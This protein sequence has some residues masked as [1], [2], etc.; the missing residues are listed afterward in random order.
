M[1]RPRTP[2]PVDP[3]SPRLAGGLDRG[4]FDVGNRAFQLIGVLGAGGD[5][6]GGAEDAVAGGEV[7]FLLE[8]VV[9][10]RGL[11]GVLDL[12]NPLTL[13]VVGDVL[14]LLLTDVA[15]GLVGAHGRV[16]RRESAAYA[17]REEHRREEP[18]VDEGS[19][20]LTDPKHALVCR[21]GP[22]ARLVLGDCNRP[23][24]GEV[25]SEVA[26]ALQGSPDD[27]VVGRAQNHS[28]IARLQPARRCEG[29][30]SACGSHR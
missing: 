25:T 12:T 4:L 29:T 24:D 3:Q 23:G 14:R 17:G 5:G 19:R 15:G 26:V 21:V 16:Q 28:E 27:W 9:V 2:G 30:G 1:L 10:L 7:R 13:G 8:D 6:P 20:P 11:S 18:R 22:D